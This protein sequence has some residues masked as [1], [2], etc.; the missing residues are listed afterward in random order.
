M[1]TINT[2]QLNNM[3]H[4]EKCQFMKEIIKKEAKYIDETW[5]EA[6]YEQMG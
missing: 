6:I 1:R 3:S 4:R 5:H 2:N